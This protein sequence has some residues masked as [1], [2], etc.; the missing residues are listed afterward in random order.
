MDDRTIIE[1]YRKRVAEYDEMYGPPELQADFAWLTQWLQKNVAGT[2]VLEVACGTG[3]WT[4]VASAT[5]RRIVASDINWNLL[6]A[7]RQKV[8]GR[9]VDF[10]VADAYNLPVTPNTFNCG[11]AHFWLSHVSRSEI[12][13]FL[14]SFCRHFK[15]GNRILFIDTKWVEGYRRPL[16]RRDEDD[17]TYQLRTL[18]DGSQFEILKN[19]F[20]GAELA[21]W[22]GAFGSVEVRELTYNWAISLEL[23]EKNQK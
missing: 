11:M 19:Y 23:H 15:A 18:K 6:H 9:D 14:K 3:H 22:L 4:K 10:L 5:A 8:E 13:S 17:N 1:Y 7:A 16:S 12:S 2:D 20:T 21:A